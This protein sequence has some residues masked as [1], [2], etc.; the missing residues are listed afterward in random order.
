MVRGKQVKL[1]QAELHINR[2]MLW[3]ALCPE[4][5]GMS[6]APLS[7]SASELQGEHLQ[8]GNCEDSGPSA[9]WTENVERTCSGH[10]MVCSIG[11]D[12]QFTGGMGPSNMWNQSL[13]SMHS[14]LAAD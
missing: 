10:S 3:Q 6:G 5:H 4:L 13:L 14:L 12:W 9:A 1:L 2:A 7:S 8:T 11:Y